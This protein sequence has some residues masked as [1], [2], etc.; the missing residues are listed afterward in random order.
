MVVVVNSGVVEYFR[1]F[2][3]LIFFIADCF[4]NS[5]LMC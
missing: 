2:F 3:F 5:I 4:F 1:V